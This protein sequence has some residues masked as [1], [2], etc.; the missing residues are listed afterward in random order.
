[1]KLRSYKTFGESRLFL[2]VKTGSACFLCFYRNQKLSERRR[3]Y[4]NLV[5]FFTG[6][7]HFVISEIVGVLAAGRLDSALATLLSSPCG[8]PL[9]GADVPGGQKGKR[10][11]ARKKMRMA[12]VFQGMLCLFGGAGSQSDLERNSLGAS[13]SGVF[14]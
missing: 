12:D 10:R 1:M 3:N 7:L 9:C 6:T 5:Y 8:T 13:D 2:R 4:G 14:F 11:S